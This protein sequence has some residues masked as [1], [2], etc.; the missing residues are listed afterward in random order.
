M[1]LAGARKI[2]LSLT[3]LAAALWTS[4]QG[5]GC[6]QSQPPEK[7][8]PGGQAGSSGKAGQMGSGGNSETPLQK[9]NSD[10]NKKKNTK[11]PKAKKATTAPSSG[12]EKN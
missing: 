5:T 8:H 1:K 10:P 6:A 11:K 7:D 4:S 12:A 3:F 2:A 9:G